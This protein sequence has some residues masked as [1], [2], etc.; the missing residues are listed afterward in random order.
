ML[1]V[2]RDRI[3]SMQSFLDHVSL[4]SSLKLDHLQLYTEHTFAYSFTP[5]A[6]AGTSPI[7]PAELARLGAHAASLGVELAPNQNCFGH[8]SGLLRHEP[9]RAL[10]ETLSDWMFLIYPRSGPFSLCPTDPASITLVQRMLDELCPCLPSP[11]LNI[12]CDETYDVGQGR[13]A[14]AVAA[15]GKAAIYADFVSKICAAALARGKTPMFWADIAAEHPEVLDRLPRPAIGA[16]WHYEPASSTN[17]DWSRAASH[18]T[19]RAMPWW[20]CPG[21]SSWRSFTGRSAE[22]SANLAEAA[23]AA[24]AH[25]AQGFLACD[26]GDL[27]HRQTWPVSLLAIAEAAEC[28]WS[29]S[30]RSARF[31]DA[32]SLHVFNDPTLRTAHWLDELGNADLPLR[33]TSGIPRD[34]AT[35]RPLPNASALFTDLHPPP[36]HRFRLP[37]DAAPWLDTLDRLDDLARRVPTGAGPLIEDELH[38]SLDQARLAARLAA[39]RRGHREPARRIDRTLLAADLHQLTRDHAR[40]WPIRSR[41]GGLASSLSFWTPLAEELR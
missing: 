32:A 20:A 12:G 40:L 7:T 9:F 19:D 10:A 13:S 29:G 39:A 4:F 31:L 36:S 5:Q 15:H 34:D 38:H 24:V 28:A 2:S 25:R 3:P 30:P 8:L 23:R 6:W 22:R 14:P 16:L 17:F 11:I 18:L 33:H 37:A 27:G 1:D 26:W 35:L 21:T 41:P